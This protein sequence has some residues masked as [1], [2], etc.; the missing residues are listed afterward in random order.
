MGSEM[1]IR[2]SGKGMQI[3]SLSNEELSEG[4]ECYDTEDF[5][6]G[7]NSFLNKTSPKFKGK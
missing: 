3:D 2:D 4:F 1:C 5:N 6:I 7:V